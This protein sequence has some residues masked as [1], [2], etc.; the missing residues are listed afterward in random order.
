MPR[1]IDVYRIYRDAALTDLASTVSANGP[2]QFEDHR[3]KK[4]TT[5]TYYIVSEEQN[6]SQSVPSIITVAP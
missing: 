1:P 4:N 6:G 5:Y 2:L 3:R